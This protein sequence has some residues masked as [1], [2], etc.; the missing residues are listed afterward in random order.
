[1]KQEEEEEEEWP[2]R[3]GPGPIQSV[4]LVVAAVIGYMTVFVFLLSCG[5]CIKG[6]E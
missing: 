5:G 1:M 3:Q 2:P 6:W 4:L